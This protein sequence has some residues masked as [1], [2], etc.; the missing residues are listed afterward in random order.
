M[1]HVDKDGRV[2]RGEGAATS[3][4]R[5]D[6]STFDWSNTF[7]VQESPRFPVG[8][9][10]VSLT[11]G[12]NP[13]SLGVYPNGDRYIEDR[14]FSYLRADGILV[15]GVVDGVGETYVG[16]ETRQRYR[17]S[18]GRDGRERC[19]GDIPGKILADTLRE[20][21]LDT[22]SAIRRALVVASERYAT[23]LSERGLGSFVSGQKHLI[24][25]CTFA[26]SVHLPDGSAFLVSGGDAVSVAIMPNGDTVSTRNQLPE[27]NQALEPSKKYLYEKFG[28]KDGRALFNAMWKEVQRNQFTNGESDTVAVNQ[29]D[30]SERFLR[31]ADRLALDQALVAAALPELKIPDTISPYAFFDGNPRVSEAAQIIPLRADPMKVVLVTD[32]CFDSSIAEPATDIKSTLATSGIEGLLKRNE[33]KDGKGGG[34]E[35]TLVVVAIERADTLNKLAC[36]PTN[37]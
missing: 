9:S 26:V 2:E 36:P 30:I 32:G 6:S 29:K 5:Q 16:Q 7:R 4:V 28:S 12:F 33:S 37:G 35:A 11:T 23:W 18:N 1:V 27:V 19:L 10:V 17:D 24:G 3:P 15:A 34:P 21:P 8:A 25:G 14:G 31:E 13:G 22:E 20:S